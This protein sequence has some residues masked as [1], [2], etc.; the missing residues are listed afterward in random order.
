MSEHSFE[1]LVGRKVLIVGEVGTGKSSLTLK[2]IRQAIELSKVKEITVIDMAPSVA[3]FGERRIGG[4]LDG[5]SNLMKEVVYLA[6][7][8]ITAPRHSARTPEELLQYVLRNKQLID[9]AIRTYKEKLTSILFINDVSIYLQSGDLSSILEL[10][11]LSRT[12]VANGY[13]GTSLARDFDTGISKLERSMMNRL[14]QSM[15]MV[16]NL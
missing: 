11:N 9:S 15:D 5:I 4:R 7:A 1:S 2:L 16:I 6:P 8:G 13:Y 12:F 10:A 3:A 14:R